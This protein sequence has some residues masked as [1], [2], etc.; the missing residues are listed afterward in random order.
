MQH[1]HIRTS[2]S[3]DH[4]PSPT[5]TTPESAEATSRGRAEGGQQQSASTAAVNSCRWTDKSSERCASTRQHR[6]VL[7]YVPDKRSWS[8]KIA[9]WRLFKSGFYLQQFAEDRA[10]FCGHK[11]VKICG[12]SG[13]EPEPIEKI[14]HKNKQRVSHYKVEKQNGVMA[15]K[16]HFFLE[17]AF[18]TCNFFKI[19]I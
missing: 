19:R 12:E 10:T 8:C 9:C 4:R 2:T 1:H 7:R 18:M 3:T 16:P 15:V 6:G 17:E 5:T 14:L 13:Q 11:N